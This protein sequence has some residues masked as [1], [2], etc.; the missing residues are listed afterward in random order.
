MLCHAL[1]HSNTALARAARTHARTHAHTH[2]RARTHNM[3]QADLEGVEVL[4]LAFSRDVDL[5]VQLNLKM[6]RE[7]RPGAHPH[8]PHTHIPTLRCTLHCTTQHNTHMRSPLT[9][10]RTHTLSHAHEGLVV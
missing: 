3:M 4:V 2:N 5:G 10:A 9:R 8:T 6:A 7:L 1:S